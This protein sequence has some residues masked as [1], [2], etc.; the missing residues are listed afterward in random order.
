[1]IVQNIV[2]PRMSLVVLLI[3]ET[4]KILKIDVVV[5]DKEHLTFNK[6]KVKYK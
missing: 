2:V 4:P 3:V 5:S 6:I 1:M